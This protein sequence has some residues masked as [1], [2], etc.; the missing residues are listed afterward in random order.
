[1]TASRLRLPQDWLPNSQRRKSSA[2]ARLLLWSRN[3]CS[4]SSAFASRWMCQGQKIWRSKAGDYS[5]IHAVAQEAAERAEPSDGLRIAL[6]DQPKGSLNGERMKSVPIL[7]KL[8]PRLCLLCFLLFFT[9]LLRLEEGQREASVAPW[10]IR[11]EIRLSGSNNRFPSNSRRGRGL[12]GRVD[13][14]I[15]VSGMVYFTGAAKSARA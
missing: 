4:P 12:R 7:G 1:M 8:T 11:P 6:R 2:M 3:T 10:R 15:F 5:R 13:M 14:V 9:G